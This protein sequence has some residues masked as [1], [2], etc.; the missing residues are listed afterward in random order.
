[1]LLECTHVLDTFVFQDGVALLWRERVQCENPNALSLRHCAQVLR[2]SG[3]PVGGSAGYSKP[4]QLALGNAAAQFPPHRGVAAGAGFIQ[5]VD[6][7]RVFCMLLWDSRNDE[8]VDGNRFALFPQRQ[9]GQ[10]FH[11]FGFAHARLTQEHKHGGIHQLA[12]G[13]DRV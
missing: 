10:G 12:N 3:V 7:N 11:R 13:D 1:M 5:C 6:K 4:L 9:L 2:V 8:V